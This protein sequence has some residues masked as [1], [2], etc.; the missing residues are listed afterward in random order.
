M[1]MPAT[2]L[3]SSEKYM[4][5]ISVEQLLDRKSETGRTAARQLYEEDFVYAGSNALCSADDYPFA[6]QWTCLQHT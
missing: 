5:Q 6:A 2:C 4:V 1:S 3:T